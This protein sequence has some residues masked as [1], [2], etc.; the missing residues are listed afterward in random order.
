ML[1]RYRDHPAWDRRQPA[2][3]APIADVSP[4][5]SPRRSISAS[6]R[7]VTP[8]IQPG[9]RK[10]WNPVRERQLARPDAPPSASSSRTTVAARRV[11]GRCCPCPDRTP[12]PART[13][14]RS[15]CPPRCRSSGPAGADLP[16]HVIQ[17]I[18]ALTSKDRP[19]VHRRAEQ[20][21]VCG[22]QFGDQSVLIALCVGIDWSAPGQQSGSP[23][24]RVVGQV[25][26]WVGEQVSA[27]RRVAACGPPGDEPCGQPSA[28]RAV[29][30]P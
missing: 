10:V 7:S 21:D 4:E 16:G 9:R 19:V 1:G 20:D 15:A 8:P 12:A 6:P 13:R 11:R 29:T 25:R 14:S 24:Q 22:K 3:P 2:D 18:Q 27:Y 5:P 23:V 30:P 17:S 28:R 26:W